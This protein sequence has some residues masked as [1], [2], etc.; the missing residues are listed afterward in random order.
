MV[1]LSFERIS[2][3]E[4]IS[5]RQEALLWVLYA[6][7]IPPH[8]GISQDALFYSLKVSGKDLGVPVDQMI[9]LLERKKIP[10]LIYQLHEERSLDLKEVF[11]QQEEIIAGQSSCL[12]PILEVLSER[13]ELC[14]IFDLLEELEAKGRINRVFGL[15]LPESYQGIPD[16]DHESVEKRIEEIRNAQR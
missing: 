4:L 10:A 6:D 12:S 3:E 11:A 7:R 1:A 5:L 8:I 14:L 16:Y 2:A 13:K 9:R 15:N